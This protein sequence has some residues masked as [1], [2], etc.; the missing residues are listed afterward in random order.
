MENGKA[1]VPG[2]VRSLLTRDVRTLTLFIMLVIL[3]VFFSALNPKNFP[4]VPNLR[5]MMLQMAETGVFALAM[6][7]VMISGGLNLSIVMLAN[8]SAAFMAMVTTGMVLGGVLTTPTARV[9]VGV[10][11]ALATGMLG[12]ALNGLFVSHFGLNALLVTTATSQLFEGIAQLITKGGSIVN[13]IPSIV[14]F[15]N[16]YVWGL[17]PNVFVLTLLCYLL[18]A[19]FANLTKYGE[20]A[21]LLGAN[22]VANQYCGNNNKRTLMTAYIISGLFSAVG[23][24][25]VFAKMGIVRSEYGST[26]SS[27]AL[28]TLVL[29]GLLLI[30]GIGKVSN[31]LL[32]LCILQVISSGLNLAGIT[33]YMKSVCWGFMLILIVLINT[34]VFKEFLR[35]LGIKR[36]KRNAGGSVPQEGI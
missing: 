36:R 16:G 9:A 19:V 1:K 30:G 8:M 13:T 11:V 3:A 27:Q 22:T 31:T 10:S 26:L 33:T 25:V 24:I 20:N 2:F 5:S 6:F 32:S 35:K 4:S 34:P 18:A 21:R 14:L 7:I 29:A 23:G 15:G 28:L 17:V 12:G